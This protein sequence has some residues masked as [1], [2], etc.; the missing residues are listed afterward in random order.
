MADAIAESI[1]ESIAEWGFAVRHPAALRALD[2][3][4]YALH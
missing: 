3:M 1:A 4:A 2:A